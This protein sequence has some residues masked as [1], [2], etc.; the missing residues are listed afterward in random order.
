MRQIRWNV[1]LTSLFHQSFRWYMITFQEL[2]QRLSKF[3]QAQGCTILQGYDLEVG[4][5]TFNP[6]TFLR[7]LGPEPF[8]AAYVEP[9]RRPTDGRYGDNP[10]RLQHYFQYQVILKPSPPN[11]QD[12]YLRSLE[13]VGLD[14]REHDIRFVH[15]DW[16]SPTLGAWGL[17]WEVWIDGME[18][19]QYTYFQAVGGQT[20][21]PITGELTIGLERLA[22]Y[23]QKVNNVYDLQWNDQFTYGDIYHRNEIEWSHYNFEEASTE[24]WFRHFQ[25][26]EREAKVLLAKKLPLP[27]YDFVMKASHAFNMLDARRYFSVTE[28]VG[29][30]AR[31][32]DLA[33]EVAQVYVES[34]EK[35]GFPLLKH[36]L[37]PATLP[38]VPAIPEKLLVAEPNAKGNFLLEVGS[39]ELPA[40]FVP[41]GMNALQK[42]LEQLLKK[43]GIAFESMRAYGTP[44][45]LTVAITGLAKGRAAE[46]T[47]RRGP[48]LSSAFDAD[49]KPTKACEGFF[50][51]IGKSITSYDA[52]L[53][54]SDPEIEIRELKGDQYLFAFTKTEGRSTAKI[55]AESLPKII[56]DL[57]F[58]KRMRW[59]DGEL[60]YARPLR[61]I[62]ALF[63]DTVLPF[64]VGDVLSGQTSQGHRQRC[65][66]T[67]VI[68][69]ADMYVKTLRDH[70]VAVDA[71]DR[72]ADI[73]LQM[74]GLETELNAKLLSKEQV[75]SQVLNL[76]EWPTL[77]YATFDESFL[78]VPKEVLISEMVEHQ[79]YFPVATHEGQLKNIF[80]ITADTQPTDSIR[81]GNQKVLS[82]RLKDGAFLYTTDLKIPLE[83]FNDKLK[84]VTFQKDLG[85]VYEKVERILKHVKMLHQMLPLG[86]LKQAERAALLCKA[87]LASAMVGEFPE[88]QGV[89]GRYYA[90]AQEEIPEVAQAIEEHWMPRGE[91]ASLPA[92]DPGILVSLADKIDNILG[93]FTVGLKPT[94][95]SDPYALRRQVLGIVRILIRGGYRI[96]LPELF[97]NCF[98]HFPEKYHNRKNEVLKDVEAFV[99]SRVK[100]VFLE[101]DVKK[102]EIEASLAQAVSDVYDTFCRVKALH[103]F[104]ATDTKFLGLFEVFKRAKGQL[105]GQKMGAF[106]S[107]LLK[108]KAEIDL[109]SSLGAVEGDFK[110]ALAKQQYSQAYSLVAQLQQPL[111][112]LFDEVKI[113]A[114]DAAVRQN[115][116]ALLQRVMALFGQLLDFNK[117]QE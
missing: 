99:T 10:N 20:L 47:E 21:K 88:L 8:R 41:K 15:D 79:K 64:A 59:G 56:A 65:P 51:S 30:I 76:V 26:Y 60:S 11:M 23:L 70:M 36:A 81:Q 95:S 17:G 75:I 45:R 57:E 18:I 107:T 83:Q 80:V 84:Q 111:A 74:T 63:D 39:E 68:T 7:A 110:Q 82:A 46:T 106:A 102:D 22:M 35:L 33:C 67:F 93:C 28:R 69:H 94:S 13:A 62:L 37:P 29:Y 3:W 73:E 96:S 72:K 58:P 48:A 115:R 89:I 34:R 19:T 31:I 43:E 105:D 14:L 25:D 53:D 86:D 101:Y 92:S 5:G 16:E 52:I 114:D 49:K 108:E 6:A 50:K 98:D 116:I 2:I 1:T 87:D 4:A 112:T 77:T 91:G 117:I 90:T 12:L 55:L 78:K 61:W 9:S 38:T 27:A 44:R 85:T 97:G 24:M 54:K 40:T 109:D 66:G 103:E 71:D 42:A 113:L 104:R 100:T 32:R